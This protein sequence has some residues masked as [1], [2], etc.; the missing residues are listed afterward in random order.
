[1]QVNYCRRWNFDYDQPIES[2]TEEDAKLRDDSGELYTVVIG[3]PTAPEQVI[4]VAWKNKHIGVIFFD[5]LKRRSLSYAF[6]RISD[7]KMFL[8]DITTWTFADDTAKAVNETARTDHAR[9]SQDGTVKYEAR[10]R[11]ANEIRRTEISGVNLD[12]NWEPVP[13]F[14]RWE[15]IIRRN[16]EAPVVAG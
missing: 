9:Y 11:A 6:T 3:D 12:I 15:S 16:R 14:G 8:D 4:E 5:A 1:V 13:V 7:D 2:L 10:D